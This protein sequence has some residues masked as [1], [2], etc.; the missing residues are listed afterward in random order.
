[1][2]AKRVVKTTDAISSFFETDDDKA[3]LAAYLKSRCIVSELASI[4][5]SKGITQAALAKQMD[6]RQA[7]ISKLESGVDADLRLSDLEAYAKAADVEFTILV[8]E[9]GKSLAEQIKHHAFAIRAAFVKLVKLAHQ[10]DLIAQGVAQLHSE[11]FENINRMLSET[12]QQLPVN[13]EN[14]MPYIQIIAQDG[15]ECA[16][17]PKVA[18]SARKRL[19]N[20]EELSALA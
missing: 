9:R 8:S 19:R 13:A 5:V 16:E 17:G 7:R 12:A 3:A 18:E 11:A 1:M 10:D 4:R 15:T 6:C 14:G 2:E 20:N